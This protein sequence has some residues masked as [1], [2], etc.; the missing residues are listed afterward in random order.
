[1][2]VLGSQLP[3]SRNG[4]VENTPAVPSLET[5]TSYCNATTAV[6]AK[7]WLT[8]WLITNFKINNVVKFWHCRTTWVNLNNRSTHA[9]RLIHAHQLQTAFIWLAQITEIVSNQSKFWELWCFLLLP[10]KC[11][12][13]KPQSQ[14]WDNV[15]I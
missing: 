7:Y 2:E 12:F 13:W 4:L 6:S 8:D 10:K 3:S 9:R 1:M 15:E 11:F 5:A 14:L